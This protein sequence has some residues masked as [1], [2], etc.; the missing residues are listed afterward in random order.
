MP[1]RHSCFISYRNSQDDIAKELAISLSTELGRW[2]D[3]DVY[4]DKGRI[5]GGDFFND[6][7]AQ[8]LCESV[9]WIVIFTPTYFSKQ[10]TYCAREYWTMEQL[11]EQRLNELG[12]PKNE[13]HGLIIPIVYRGEKKL[14]ESIKENR[15]YLL[16]EDYQIGGRDNLENEE[17]AKKIKEIAEYIDERCDQLREVE[18]SVCGC[19]DTI[20]FPKESDIAN[21]LE[22]MLSPKQRLPSRMSL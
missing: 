5:K 19:C 2:L 14:P 10:H 1:L 9:C 13:K 15:A 17:Y 3:M 22:G 8:A 21:W 12:L 11:E 7:L 20:S 4:V 18:H 6:E 16:F